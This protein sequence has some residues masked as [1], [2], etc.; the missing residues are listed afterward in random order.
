MRAAT[1]PSVEQWCWRLACCGV[2]LTSYSTEK[3]VW[4]PL[5]RTR[6]PALTALDPGPPIVEDGGVRRT[7]AHVLALLWPVACASELRLSLVIADGNTRAGRTS[8]LK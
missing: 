7:W 8:S 1:A 2:N 6:S 5:L 3:H 4:L